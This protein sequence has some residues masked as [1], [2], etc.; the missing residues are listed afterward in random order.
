MKKKLLLSALLIC[1]GALAFGMINAC[2]ETYGDLTYIISNNEV[3]ITNCNTSAS[4]ELVIPETIEGYPVAEI[5]YFAFENCDALTSITIP[6]SV[7]LID[8]FAFSNCDNLKNI[9]IG[10][11]V[12]TMGLE[13]FEDCTSLT[14][15]II[16]DSVTSM[17]YG[18][19]D[20][21]TSL[22]DA[23]IG[24]GLTIIEFDTFNNC[25]SLENL[26]I[27][28]SVTTIKFAFMNCWSLR[29]L[30]IPENVTN[31]DD[32]PFTDD[33]CQVSVLYRP[34]SATWTYEFDYPGG[35]IVDVCKVNYKKD[36]EI[37]SSEYV[38]LN[39]NAKLLTP[40]EGY[41]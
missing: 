4:G 30:L 12:T 1:I 28:S 7:I 13:V 25:S 40:P 2:A 14:S 20:G 27:G 5:S 32:Q 10:N 22:T 18:A 11:G 36:G 24:N 39:Q 35:K 23:I 6:D 9:T 21:C 29:E 16:P 19:F 3:T 8:D 17:G 15:I 26:T 37:I 33:I 41:I 31:L 34:I 38:V